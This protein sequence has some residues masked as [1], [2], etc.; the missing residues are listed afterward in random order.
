MADTDIREIISHNIRYFR[1]LK[2][3]SQEKLSRKCGLSLRFITR[4]ENDPQ[5]LT[6]LSLDT[7]AKGLEVSMSDLVSDRSAKT[8]KLSAKHLKKTVDA[9]STTIKTLEAYKAQLDSET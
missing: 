3:L 7:I 5:N 8:A 4:A 9:I 6:I 1:K 2:G